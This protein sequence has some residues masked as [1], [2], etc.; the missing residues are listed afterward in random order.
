MTITL[1]LCILYTLLVPCILR[2]S[3]HFP[4][5]LHPKQLYLEE[6]RIYQEHLNVTACFHLMSSAKPEKV[7]TTSSEISPLT[8]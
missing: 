2:F 6:S 8:K 7:K 1:E 3:L 4:S 5:S